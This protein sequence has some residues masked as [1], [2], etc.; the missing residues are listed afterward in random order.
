MVK[1]MTAAHTRAS[2]AQNFHHLVDATRDIVCMHSSFKSL[3]PAEGGA[4]TVVAA[5]EDAVGRD[6]LI[7]MPSF[8]LVPWDERPKTWDIEKSPSTV[9]WITEF[10]RLMSGTYRSDH[11]SH[12]SAA[13]GKN[14]KEF[15]AGHLKREGLKSRWDRGRWGRAFGGDS[16]MVRAYERDGKIL[17]MGVDYD[18]STYVHLAECMYRT[19]HI[20]KDGEQGAHPIVCRGKI[21]EYWESVRDINRGRVGDADCRLFPIRDY[22]DTAFAELERNIDA[23][24]EAYMSLSGERLE[25]P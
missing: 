11:C 22:V 8:N 2:L 17:M 21:G 6:G 23:Y 18:S 3:G 10:F 5:L 19:K 24:V 12:S 16:P 20:D 15:V 4:G 13:R 7:L 9:G 1:L 25:R 14:A